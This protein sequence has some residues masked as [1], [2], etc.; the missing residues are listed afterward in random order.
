MSERIPEDWSFE[1][2]GNS[3]N[4][5]PKSKSPSGLS[6]EDGCFNFYVCSSDVQKSFHC[7]TTQPSVLFSTGG[8]AA[9]HYANGN[10]AYST[11]VWAT[12]FKGNLTNEYVYRFLDLNLNQISYSGF[13][14]SGIKHL[15]KEFIRKLNIPAPPLPEQKKIATI[16]T[17]IDEVIENTKKQ[18]GKLQ[19]IKKATMNEL[20]TKGID[21]TEFKDSEL[22]RIPKSWEV[23]ILSELCEGRFGI[24]DGPFGSNLKTKHYRASGVPVI[25][26]G[27][28]TSGKFKAGN[29][30]YVEESKYRQEIRSS[31][32]GGDIVM[33]KIG[34][35]AGKCAI[36]PAAHPT[37]ILAGN[38]LKITARIAVIKTEF[39]FQLLT[40]LYKIGEIQKLRTE[41]AQ[42]AISIATLKKYKITV[43]P[44]GEQN[45]ILDGLVSIDDVLTSLSIKLQKNQSLK[46]SLMQ[47]LLTGKVRVHVHAEPAR[48]VS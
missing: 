30:V 41:T 18:I 22:G 33:A 25:Q 47:D 40:H 34:A 38:S 37:G 4:P 5:L 15:D 7:E 19:D 8:E 29:Y 23:K 28:V 32:R 3:L 2:L 45:K 43:P 24:V 36:I 10:Y 27:F 20:L 44:M 1:T 26:S 9:V 16:L 12:E 39:L 35:Q 14:G 31:V 13:Q 46:K 6:S 42:P 21:H 17:S 48:S 11:D